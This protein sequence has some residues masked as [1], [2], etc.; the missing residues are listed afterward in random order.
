[1]RK[2]SKN[3]FLAI[4]A[5]DTLLAVTKSEKLNKKKSL[6]QYGG[7]TEK[8]EWVR[9]KCCYLEYDWKGRPKQS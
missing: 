4:L 2:K 1:M 5:F 6:K 7:K 8:T 3:L 9:K